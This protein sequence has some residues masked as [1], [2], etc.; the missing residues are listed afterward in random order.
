MSL[1]LQ[2]RWSSARHPQIVDQAQQTEPEQG[3]RVGTAGCAGALQVPPRRRQVFRGDRRSWRHL[4][5]LMMAADRASQ[6]TLRRA[7]AL[8]V[9][10]MSLD[11]LQESRHPQSSRV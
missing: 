7:T 3:G 10:R 11:D 2:R 9:V 6:P 4:Q 5:H 1:P 8:R